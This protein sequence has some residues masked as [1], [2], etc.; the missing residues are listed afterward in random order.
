MNTAPPAPAR[1]GVRLIA[2]SLVATLAIGMAGYLWTGNPAATSAAAAAP[3]AGHSDIAP[4][5]FA[6]MVDK[7]ALKLKDKPDPVGFSMLGRSYLVMGRHEESVA[8]Y[9]KAI[10]L[11][12]DDA[13]LMADMADAVAM[14]NGGRLDGEP[15]EWIERAL[16]LEP[17]HLKALSLRGAAAFQRQD[18]A[19]AAASWDR[20]VAIG[21]AD[22]EL[23]QG[24]RDGAEQARQ[25]GKLP[26][27]PVDR[28]AAA[29]GGGA[30]AGTVS[31]SPTLK[32]QAS[33]DD[34]VFIFARPAEGSRMPLA[35]ARKQ[36]K[37]LPYT[38]RLDDAMAMSPQATLSKA[39]R[40]IVGARVSKSGQ[41]MPQAG[42][43][44][45]LSAPVAVG[46]EGIVVTI[47]EAL[48]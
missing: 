12:G 10:E 13:S 37:D 43:L 2:V 17:A 36:V 33:P 22:S 28:P 25:A 29:A 45:G 31:L 20:V 7:L 15:T 11:K 8:A 24:A 44:E 39:G 47:S 4:A 27:A 38:F 40:V 48:R 1:A 21:P 26:A 32:A 46:T 41:A 18:F 23:V 14:R 9:R 35:I 3:P 30:V 42:D 5:Q 34:T 16:K 6:E 19:A